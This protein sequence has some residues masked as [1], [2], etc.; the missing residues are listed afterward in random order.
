MKVVLPRATVSPTGDHFSTCNIFWDAF[1]LGAD[2]IVKLSFFTELKLNWK[3][4]R[5]CQPFLVALSRQ[6]EQSDSSQKIH[7]INF[8]LPLP[9]KLRQAGL[10]EL[11]S[12]L[13][14]GR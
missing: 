10:E 8:M 11:D 12:G 13:P 9:I 4:C 5:Y 6:S 1:S 14:S 2:E 7:R 3:G